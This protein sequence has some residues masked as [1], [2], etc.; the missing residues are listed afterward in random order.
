MGVQRSCLWCPSPGVTAW[1]Y[2]PYQFLMLRNVKIQAQQNYLPKPLP[3]AQ[4]SPQVRIKKRK[5]CP[6]LVPSHATIARH[7]NVVKI[8]F[9]C[10]FDKK[11]V[12]YVSDDGDL[13]KRTWHILNDIVLAWRRSVLAAPNDVHSGK[14]SVILWSFLQQLKANNLSIWLHFDN[15]ATGF[16]WISSVGSS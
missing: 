1:L 16:S 14:F 3:H 12:K 9:Y 13:L 11:K 2:A 6:G 5:S 7:L 4:A 8:I 10:T 15:F